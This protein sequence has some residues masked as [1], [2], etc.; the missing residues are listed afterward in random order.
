[1]IATNTQNKYFT[2]IL[3]NSPGV[4]Q[5]LRLNDLIYIHELCIDITH[6]A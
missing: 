4:T 2:F 6:C 1:M 3:R 5:N